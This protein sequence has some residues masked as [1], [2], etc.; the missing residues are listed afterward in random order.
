MKLWNFL[1]KKNQTTKE[2]ISTIS[3]FLLLF[4]SLGYLSGCS[5]PP[6]HETTPSQTEVIFQ[7]PTQTSTMIATTRIMLTP[8]KTMDPLYNLQISID[9]TQGPVIISMISPESEEYL[10]KDAVVTITLGNE[11]EAI[12]YLNLDDLSENGKKNSDV[13]ILNTSGSM[14][15]Y[16]LFPINNASY[17]YSER[18]TID[19]DSCVEHFPIVGLTYIEYYAQAKFF[20][21]GNAFCVITNEGL[22]ATISFVKDSIK[23]NDD[24]SKDLQIKV[25]VYNKK[26]E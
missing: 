3:L 12:A 7:E 26:M 4:V 5:T 8:T 18:N 23:C 22:V 19:Y 6:T 1:K 10:Y 15:F 24:Y 17:F 21:E 13:E 16:H 9:V 11:Q 25:T 2:T 20:L 14:T